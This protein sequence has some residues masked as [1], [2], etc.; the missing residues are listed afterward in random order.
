MSSSYNT[1]GGGSSTL[2]RSKRISNISS[3]SLFYGSEDGG[4]SYAP[5]DS[6]LCYPDNEL[7]SDELSRSNS[8]YLESAICGDAVVSNCLSTGVAVSHDEQEPN[9]IRQAFALPDSDKWK[10]AVNVELEMIR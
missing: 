9:T 5:Y 10:E 4:V 8:S 3:A 1:D 7:V 6:H 2:R